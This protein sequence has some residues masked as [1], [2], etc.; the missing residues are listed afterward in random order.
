MVSRFLKSCSHCR[1]AGKGRR[2][3]RG[4]GGQAKVRGPIRQRGANK[5]PMNHG[6]G[7]RCSNCPSQR[8][9]CQADFQ[10][11]LPFRH[12]LYYR[13]VLQSPHKTKKAPQRVCCGASQT[14]C[15]AGSN[16]PVQTNSNR[17]YR[18]KRGK[19][20]GKEKTISSCACA[21]HVHLY[22][23]EGAGI[24]RRISLII[25]RESTEG[26]CELSQFA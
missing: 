23:P 2:D 8:A 3:I 24:D 20:D 10:N 26:K 12:M 25:T 22:T 4:Y 16:P 5:R 1:K 19:A 13:P 9:L 11:Y 6:F 7:G 18:K 15:K 21:S 14:L 17:P